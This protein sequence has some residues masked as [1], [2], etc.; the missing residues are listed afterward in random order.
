MIG[1]LSPERL[2]FLSPW[3]PVETDT[4][5]QEGKPWECPSCMEERTYFRSLA[6]LEGNA[7]RFMIQ[8]PQ[9]DHLAVVAVPAGE[10][11]GLE[12]EY[13]GPHIDRFISYLDARSRQADQK[14]G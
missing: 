11:G 1:Y 7:L 12:T 3:R 6:R 14:K 13:G 4:T 2:L 9:C 8:C 10:G 5:P